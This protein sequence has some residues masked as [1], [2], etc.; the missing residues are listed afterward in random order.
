MQCQ[1]IVLVRACKD[2]FE[3]SNRCCVELAF[4]RLREP[5][6]A[7]WLGIASRYGRSEVSGVVGVGY[8]DDSPRDKRMSS[9]TAHRDSLTIDLLVMVANHSRDFRVLVH[10]REDALADC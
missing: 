3:G 2:R 5:K 6:L 8:G 7:T 9:S 10:M 4:N 1:S